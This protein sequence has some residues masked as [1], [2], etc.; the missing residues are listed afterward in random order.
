ML[1]KGRVQGVGYRAFVVDVARTLGL[2]GWVRNTP[3]GDVQLEAQ[4]AD[5]N[6]ERLA[7]LLKEGPSL[8]H[9]RSV[10]VVTT[11]RPAYDGF[12]IRW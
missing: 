6:L 7:E 9:A 12:D 11:E 3:E 1:V 4:G 10:T 2:S 5:E 8:A